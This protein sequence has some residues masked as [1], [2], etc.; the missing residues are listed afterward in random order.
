MKRISNRESGWSTMDERQQLGPKAH[1]MIRAGREFLVEQI[2]QS[3]QTIERAQA[4]L[5]QVDELPRLGQ[6]T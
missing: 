4:L 6:D 3:Q 5:K 2:R 1:D